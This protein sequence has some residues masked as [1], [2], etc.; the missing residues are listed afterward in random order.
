MSK[1]GGGKGLVA[2]GRGIEDMEGSDGILLA[3]MCKVVPLTAIPAAVVALV[4]VVVVVKVVALL[5]F[6]TVLPLLVMAANPP[7]TLV[8]AAIRLE[9]AF[10][11]SLLRCRDKGAN[12]AASKNDEISDWS[13]PHRRSRSPTRRRRAH[14]ASS[15]QLTRLNKTAEDIAKPLSQTW[16]IYS[17][18]SAMFFLPPLK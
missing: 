5:A 10:F 7:L 12:D 6:L 4:E 2:L 15:R 16:T 9:M 17:M 8:L 1:T 18:N 13:R 14:C 3:G 11:S